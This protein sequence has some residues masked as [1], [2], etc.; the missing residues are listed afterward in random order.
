M[1]IN[2]KLLRRSTES[3]EES[4]ETQSYQIGKKWP[5]ITFQETVA[6]SET[7]DD[8]L[9]ENGSKEFRT[10]Y[11]ALIE[12]ILKEGN[13]PH[14]YAYMVD[15]YA[16]NF[17]DYALIERL[18]LKGARFYSINGKL[19]SSDDI[20]SFSRLIGDGRKELFVL[21]RRQ[22]D[23]VF[24]AIQKGKY[25]KGKLIGYKKTTEPGIREKLHPQCT[26]VR[27]I[28]EEF[29]T[30]NHSI[31][32]F[33]KEANDIAVNHNFKLSSKDRLHALLVNPA[34]AG[35]QKYEGDMY[36]LKQESIIT[37]G[38]YNRNMSILAGRRRKKVRKYNYIY[39][40]FL[41]T[42]EGFMFSGEI[43]KGKFIYYRDSARKYKYVNEDKID[44]AMQEYM[45]Q[46]IER[47]DFSLI[48]QELKTAYKG[49]DIQQEYHR[50]HYQAQ[51]LDIDNR[52]KRIRDLRI[53]DE[54]DAQEFSEMR[55]DLLSQ[56]HKLMDYNQK[57]E[58]DKL[59]TF[60]QYVENTLELVDNAFSRYSSLSDETKVHILK[61]SVRTLIW[62]EE[63]LT[64][65]P[66][67]TFNTLL[68]AAK[69]ANGRQSR[70]TIRTLLESIFKI[71]LIELQRLVAIF[72]PA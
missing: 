44:I 21:R 1:I 29:S 36:P 5:S 64:V 58:Y 26:G 59:V 49:F 39:T 37:L 2:I 12:K 67:S 50:K 56:K 9:E 55:D 31:R 46:L 57:E 43:K 42:P 40:G 53:D 60:E 65:E 17:Y 48:R 6:L 72:N 8:V 70:D 16:R 24:T 34:Y 52:L 28:L 69:N 20:D 15:R 61:A 68:M 23:G 33:L 14:T 32:S 25:L 62:D 71:P 63:K 13:E 45:D 35:F 38:T 54:I 51:L 7:G 22:R 47:V 4:H 11:I 19:E 18:M 27:K 10:N 3:Q 66:N 41:T 30:G